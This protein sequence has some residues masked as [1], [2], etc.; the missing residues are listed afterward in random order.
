LVDHKVWYFYPRKILSFKG[1]SLAGAKTNRVKVSE[2]HFVDA[3]DGRVLMF[4]GK[5]YPNQTTIAKPNVT[6]VH[7]KPAQSINMILTI[8]VVTV[9]G[10][11]NM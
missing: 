1:L 10:R 5:A 8:N 9:T 4:R 6:F 11:K 3:Q 2:G 7:K